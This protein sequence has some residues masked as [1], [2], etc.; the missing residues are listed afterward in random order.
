MLAARSPQRQDA[1]NYRFESVMHILVL[2]TWFPYPP[3]NGSKIRAHYLTRALSERHDVTLVGFCPIA[4]A[5]PAQL[6]RVKVIP[7]PDDPFRHVDKSQI[8]KYASPIPLAF[9]PSRTMQRTIQQLKASRRFDAVV[10]IQTPAAQYAVSMPSVARVIDIDTSLSYQMR[11][12]YE[13]NLNADARLRA[14]ISWQKTHRYEQRI[15]RK[16]QALAVVSSLEVDF[17]AAMI[18]DRG[19]CVKVIRNGVDCEQFRPGQYPVQPNTLIYNGALTYSA[20]YDAMQYFLPT[21]YPLIRQQIP[22]VTLTITGSTRGV[23]M[24]GLQLNDSVKLPG[25]IDDM[26]PVVGSSTVCVVPIRQG[27]GTRLK[28]LEAMAAGTPVVT[29]A[30]G[31][32]GLDVVDGEHVLLADDAKA[33]ADKTIWLLRNE[34][35]RRG[36]TLNA[37]RFVEQRYDWRCIGQQ[38]AETVESAAGNRG[39]RDD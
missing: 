5:N 36:L 2:S 33:F 37:R 22:E 13:H 10:A 7:V 28:I 3:D 38:F 26:R 11:Q 35:L 27:S 1:I 32:E 8:V 19:G 6:D 29:T 14:W 18:K 24:K 15:F 25:Y 39:H 4:A 17:V 20:N 9:W 31:V 16:F 23:D 30:K 12:R 21:I 34:S